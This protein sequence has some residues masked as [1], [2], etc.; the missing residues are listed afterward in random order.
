M[1]PF[2]HCEA[3]FLVVSPPSC[4]TWQVEIFPVTFMNKGAGDGAGPGI[5]I[6]VTTP[7]GKVYSVIVKVELYI[8]HGMRQIK[9]DDR[10]CFMP[11]VCDCLHIEKTGQ[12]NIVRPQKESGKGSLHFLR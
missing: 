11:A 5:Q 3:L 8:S 4:K 12:C 2:L 6:F 10:A 7:G 9:T 1:E